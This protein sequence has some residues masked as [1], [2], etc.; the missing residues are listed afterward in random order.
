MKGAMSDDSPL[1]QLGGLAPS[2]SPPL[3]EID[4][5]CKMRVLPETAAARYDYNGKTYFFCATRCME[6]F[7]ADP[8]AFLTPSPA[9]AAAEDSSAIYTCPMHPEIRQHGFGTCP[10]C[11]MALEPEVAQA[12][13]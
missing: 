6:R 7:K 12:E 13:E 5:V 4:P 3:F 8:S 9:K 10:K 2:G 11:G 1:V